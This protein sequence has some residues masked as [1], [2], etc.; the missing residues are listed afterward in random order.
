MDRRAREALQV[1]TRTMHE[2][3]AK[4]DGADPRVAEWLE[5]TA[6][7]VSSFVDDQEG[8]DGE[9]PASSSRAA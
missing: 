9:D 1:V 7:D 6:E 2:Q 4:V 3:A 5:M 8:D